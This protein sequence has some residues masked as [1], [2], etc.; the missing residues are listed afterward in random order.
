MVRG[1]FE[2]V[3]AYKSHK[4]QTIEQSLHRHRPEVIYEENEWMHGDV[5]KTIQP[6]TISFLCVAT[7]H[8]H[9]HRTMNRNWN[10]NTPIEKEQTRGEAGGGNT[11]V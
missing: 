11:M 8:L 6:T 10:R 7:P 3:L 9:L 4:V 1:G 2:I 5:G